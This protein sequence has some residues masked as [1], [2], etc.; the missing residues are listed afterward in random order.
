MKNI[1]KKISIFMICFV[2][3]TFI[4]AQATIINADE[5][6]DKDDFIGQAVTWYGKGGGNSV[7]T[8]N[9]GKIVQIINVAGTAIIAIATVVLGIKYMLSS[10]TGKSDVKQ[11]LGSLLVACVFFF[12]WS[13]LSNI[14]IDGTTYNSSTGTY[15][16]VN[17]NTQLFIFSDLTNADSTS[18]LFANIFAIVVFAARLIAVVVTMII[19]AKYIFGSSDVKSSIKEKG[20]MYIMG[21]VMSLCTVEVLNFISKAINESFVK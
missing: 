20:P 11:Q 19:G 5:E 7:Q 15:S 10:A 18:A 3:V 8:I 4:G 12:G 2:L 9:L 14:L 21:L 1:L 6:K 13:N 17:G 16:G